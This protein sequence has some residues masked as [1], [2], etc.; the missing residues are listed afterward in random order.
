MAVDL[1]TI[2]PSDFIDFRNSWIEESGLSAVGADR[3]FDDVGLSELVE[4]SNSELA[5]YGKEIGLTIIERKRL[6]KGINKLNGTK[7]PKS[8]G[9][10]KPRLQ[11]SKT[12]PVSDLKHED[13]FSAAGRAKS[14]RFA[15]TTKKT[16]K[17]PP[18]SSKKGRPR[19]ARSNSK[20]K[21]KSPNGK[22]SKKKRKSQRSKTLAI[23]ST[24]SIDNLMVDNEPHRPSPEPLDIAVAASVSVT[25]EGPSKGMEAMLSEAIES[26]T[27]NAYAAKADIT[28]TFGDLRRLLTER[29]MKL[30]HDVDGTLERKRRLLQSQLDYE[31]E[32]GGHSIT[33][34]VAEP[35]LSLQME[36]D[37]IRRTLATAGWV[38]GA[39]TDDKEERYRQDRERKRRELARWQFECVEKLKNITVFERECSAKR[40]D[41]VRLTAEVQQEIRKINERT[42]RCEREL[43][44]ARPFLESAKALVSQIA[45]KDLDELRA[46]KKPPPVVELVMSS[47][48]IMLG[49]KVQSWRDIQ[50]VLS[51]FK[52]V[53]SIMQFDTATLKK[54]TRAEVIKYTKHE[55]FNEERAARAS[56][57]AGSLVK[58]VESQIKYSELLDIVRPT[59][60]EIKSL[61]KELDRKQKKLEHCVSLVAGLEGKIS[62]SRREINEMVDAMIKM[63][64]QYDLGPDDGTVAGKVL[65]HKRSWEED[66]DRRLSL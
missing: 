29:E 9:G 12:P 49:N 59:Q 37:Q 28:A 62:K 25:S 35:A 55:D 36:R 30:L 13:A 14:A 57:V 63:Q 5:E 17:S 48:V 40:E 60:R 31:R 46:L 6:I 52:F 20:R 3:L 15:T 11:F 41:S 16:K 54:K 66:H 61:R 33:E 23:M 43:D 7:P 27:N 8:V 39:T 10:G 26:L 21:N 50:R 1:T 18:S 19:S 4:L 65:A 45:K 44:E 34:L 32:S 22:R 56:K 38:L 42:A 64:E 47:V 24:A 53:A 51:S 58:W 2:D